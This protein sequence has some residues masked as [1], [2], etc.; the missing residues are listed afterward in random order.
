MNDRERFFDRP[1]RGEDAAARRA[2]KEHKRQQDWYDKVLEE[3]RK[4][5]EEI[6]RIVRENDPGPWWEQ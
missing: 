4:H 2:R 3:R 1:T 6:D 5:R